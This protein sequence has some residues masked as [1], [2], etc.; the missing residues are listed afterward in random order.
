MTETEWQELSEPW[1][2]LE[3]ISHN[4]Y[5]SLPK[6]GRFAGLAGPLWLFCAACF[7]EVFEEPLPP[8]VQGALEILEAFGTAEESPS[9]DERILQAFLDLDG[10]TSKQP[11]LEHQQTLTGVL[12]LAAEAMGPTD[13]EYAYKA[14]DLITDSEQLLSGMAQCNLLREIFGEAPEPVSWNPEWRSDAVMATAQQI[15]D[16]RNFA[17]MANLADLLEQ[18]GCHEERILSHCRRAGGHVPG[19]W[20]LDL[21]AWRAR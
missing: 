7:R 15:F 12:T 2:L 17:Q 4:G 18:Q 6:E 10:I 1:L 3:A 13:E 16:Q 14:S 21:L 5:G 11:E 19:C 20:A 8:E 9:G